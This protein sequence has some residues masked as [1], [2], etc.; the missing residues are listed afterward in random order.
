MMFVSLRK[1][2]IFLYSLSTGL[3]LC[4]V[5]AVLFVFHI[6]S[7]SRQ[8]ESTFQNHLFTLTARLQSGSLFSDHELA[9]MELEN[10]LL[11]RIEE[12]KTPLF[13]S[14]AYSAPSDREGLIRR[15]ESAAEDSGV[16]TGS[17]PLSS[18]LIRSPLLHI[19]GEHADS[20][21]AQVVV[22]RTDS[23]YRKL[24]L[25]F[26]RTDFILDLFK[27]ALLYL[28]AATLGIFL[29]FLTGRRFVLR[30][31]EPAERAYRS[32]QEFISS[33]SHELRS[34]LAVIKASAAAISDSPG[35]TSQLINAILSECRRGSRLMNDL[36]LLASADRGTLSSD[37]HPFEIDE[38]LLELLELYEPLCFSR[39]ASL[40]LKL[41][42]TPLP[43]ACGCADLCRQIIVI[44]LDNALTYGLD[45]T[46]QGCITL[47]ADLCGRKLRVAVADH[48]PG[49]SP[50]EKERV[51][52]RFYQKD[53]SRSG[54]EHFG[55]GLSIA[56]KLADLQDITIRIEDTP[57]G[58]CTFLL[59]IN[60]TG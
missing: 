36:L 2:L 43:P 21:L 26:D 18:E 38:L 4:L 45:E 10:H 28:L 39:G 27:T 42:E 12:N 40:L 55:L 24:T 20:Y 25:L 32:Q 44:L 9:R 31:L 37:R 58:G 11:I 29:L 16:S 7:A 22:V 19:R 6:S 3:I 35:Q 1:K 48:G 49:L 8:Q 33:A 5:L 57:G 15:A 46:S 50:E 13:F 34:P 59:L 30:A 52:D 17:A 23:G 41:P 47:S 53:R 56:S 51:F 14:G 54:K 60:T